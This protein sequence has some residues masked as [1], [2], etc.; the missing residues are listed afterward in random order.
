[1]TGFADVLG[2]ACRGLLKLLLVAAAAVFVFSLL[3]ATVVVVLL[4]S[5][6]AL[7]TGRT[8]APV[9]MFRRL[10]EQSQRYRQGVWPGRTTGAPGDVVEVEA[11]EVPDS[12]AERLR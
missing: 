10:R 11:T 4:V 1:M 3:L 5:L 12:P 9:V 6:G 2:R 8:P 7:I